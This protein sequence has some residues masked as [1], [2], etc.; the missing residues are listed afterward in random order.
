MSRD[1]PS[2]F[3]RT[4]LTSWAPNFREA[5]PSL[6]R[7]AGAKAWHEMRLL[8]VNPDHVRDLGTALRVERLAEELYGKRREE[9]E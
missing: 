9:A 6:G 5:D 2:G 3:E 7:A 4:S 8:V 1:K